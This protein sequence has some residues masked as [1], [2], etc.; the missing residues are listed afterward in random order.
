MSY[1]WN[2]VYRVTDA[3]SSL[4]FDVENLFTKKVER[5]HARR[6]MMYRADM[7]GKEVSKDLLK[8]VE[9]CATSYQTVLR[10]TDIR[11]TEGQLQ[12]EIEWDGLPDREDRTWENL[13]EMNDHIPGLI[14]D[15]LNSAKKRNIKRRALS[16]L[17]LT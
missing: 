16:N 10:I 8:Y 5:A 12:I 17:Q 14:H 6:L 15:F 4:V 13:S 9:H 3:V 2:G 7:D 11:D 1:K